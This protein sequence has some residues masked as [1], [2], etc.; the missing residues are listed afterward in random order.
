MEQT[1]RG[2][3]WSRVDRRLKFYSRSTIQI[4]WD[5]FS[6]AEGDGHWITEPE[7]FDQI[8]QFVEKPCERNQTERQ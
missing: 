1:T 4:E 7:G 2:C 8:L 6:G 3:L 5:A